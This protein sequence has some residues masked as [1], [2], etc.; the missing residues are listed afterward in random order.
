M[1]RWRERFAKLQSL[2]AHFR[3]N[4]LNFGTD[5]VSDAGL[6]EFFSALLAD[7]TGKSFACTIWN[8]QSDDDK[9]AVID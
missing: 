6:A 5:M 3:R 7:G 1:Y 4:R 8:L 2:T 9:A